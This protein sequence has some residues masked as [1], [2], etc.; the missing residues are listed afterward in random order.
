MSEKH[1][2]GPC[3][4]P[5]KA[6]TG[7]FT[8]R[9]KE[10]LLAAAGVFAERG[11]HGCRTQDIADRLDLKQASLYYYFPTK[12]AA[13]EAVCLYAVSEAAMR[14][15]PLLEDAEAA[16]P[17]T[18]RRV[19]HA[20][21]HDLQTH[22]D[23]MI[24]LN[25]QRRHLPPEQQASIRVQAHEYRNLLLQLF[26]QARSRGEIRGDV[27]CALAAHALIDLCHGAALRLQRAPESESG[28]DVG[29]IIEQYTRLFCAGIQ[30]AAHPQDL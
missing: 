19:I 16:L 25:E 11:F 22:R 5:S 13:L 17:E 7:K 27:D 8:R 2:C 4:D 15:R 28:H 21:L 18:I 23:C 10:I 1:I 9:R 26:E 20:Y 6:P 12:E 3:P 14:L 30:E 24:V 29:H